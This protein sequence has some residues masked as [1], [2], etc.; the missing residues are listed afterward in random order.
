MK[1]KFVFAMGFFLCLSLGS[2]SA[3]ACQKS[4][5]ACKKSAQVSTPAPSGT[6]IALSKAS[7]CDPKNCNPANCN[8]ANCPPG[9]C[10]VNKCKKAKTASTTKAVKAKSM[11]L[12]ASPNVLVEN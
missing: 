6:V 8:P 1:M 9:A 7:N 12:K 2:L 11:A 4:K 3:Q 5:V 10:D